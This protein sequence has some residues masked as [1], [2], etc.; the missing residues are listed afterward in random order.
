MIIRTVNTDGMKKL[1]DVLGVE[2]I[3][4][5]WEV[6]GNEPLHP[7][8]AIASRMHEVALSNCE[9]GCKVYGDPRSSVHILAH[10][11]SYGCPK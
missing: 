8:P 5:T 2:A 11:R 6:S 10:N 9:Y 1:A 3:R 4:I 7:D